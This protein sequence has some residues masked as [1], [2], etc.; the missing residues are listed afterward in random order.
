VAA[1]PPADAEAEVEAEEFPRHRGPITSLEKLTTDEIIAELDRRERRAR[2]LHARQAALQAELA[3][4][5]AQLAEVGRRLA[6]QAAEPAADTED[7][8][9]PHAPR[10]SGPRA[11][12]EISLADAIAQSVE[13]RARITPSEAAELVRSNGYVTNARNF[14]M[15]VATALSKDSRFRRIERGV[16]ERIADDEAAAREELDAPHCPPLGPGGSQ[17]HKGSR[18]GPS[19]GQC[20]AEDARGCGVES[21]PR[22][23]S[24]G[25]GFAPR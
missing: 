2:H 10:R 23:A 20:S 18:P 8:P 24:A 11:R 19:A 22:V 13:I 9:A 15:T 21:K 14:A 12:N 16:Y 4:L 3:E 25:G 5:D 6:A 17:Q 1:A 7:A